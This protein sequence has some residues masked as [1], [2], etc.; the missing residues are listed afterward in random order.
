MMKEYRKKNY[1]M[2]AEKVAPGTELYNYLEDCYYTTN[3]T[4]CIKLIGTVGEVWPVTIEKL[5][6]TY[7]LK[8][9][10]PITPVN[11]PEGEFEIATIVDETA[12]TVFAEQ[13]TE[14]VQVATSWGEVLTAN[15]DGVPHGEGDFIVSAN[16]DGQ[17]N[18]A[19]RWVV[20]GMV[21]NNTYEEV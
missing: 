1:T 17:P 16:K 20:N 12:E 4:K 5:A 11:I 6:K 21:F 9:G 13:V 3:E 15:R 8:D 10:T 2:K 7:T 18:P 19:D 14:Q